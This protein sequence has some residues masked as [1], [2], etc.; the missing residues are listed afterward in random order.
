MD[1]YRRDCDIATQFALDTHTNKR[2]KW[3]LK[4]GTSRRRSFFQ[5]SL[6][7]ELEK[8]RFSATVFRQDRDSMSVFIEAQRAEIEFLKSRPQNQSQD[9]ELILRMKRDIDDLKRELQRS[10]D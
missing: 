5:K 1:E 6:S 10:L 7:D 3:R 8:E 4:S 2:S 9:G